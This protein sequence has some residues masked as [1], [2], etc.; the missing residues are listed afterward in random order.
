MSDLWIA[1]RRLMK[2]RPCDCNAVYFGDSPTFR[3]IISSSSRS[4]GKPN[5]KPGQI[6][7]YSWL[8]YSSTLKME[9][10]CSSE[11]WGCFRSARRYNPEDFILHCNKLVTNIATV[12]NLGIVGCTQTSVW[13]DRQTGRLGQN[14]LYRAFRPWCYDLAYAYRQTCF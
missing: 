11:T 3:R 14:S 10:I 13:G 2:L 8:A 6:E 1:Q 7:L 9:S 4:K 5:E 12:R